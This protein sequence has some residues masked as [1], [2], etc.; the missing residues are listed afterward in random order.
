MISLQLSLSTDEVFTSDVLTLADGR[1]F[2][3]IAIESADTWRS[4]IILGGTDEANAKQ[5]DAFAHA[6]TVAAERLRELA[7]ADAVV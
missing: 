7:N 2:I 1:R 5:A 6:L 4:S 3:S